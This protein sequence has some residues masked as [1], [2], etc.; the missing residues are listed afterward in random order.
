MFSVEL[1]PPWVQVRWR[2][3]GGGEEEQQASCLVAICGI[4]TGTG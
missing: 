1:A 3:G 2:R 4:S